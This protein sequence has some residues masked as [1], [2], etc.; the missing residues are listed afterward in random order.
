[1]KINND[2]NLGAN[3]YNLKKPED[4][5]DPGALLRADGQPLN[6]HSLS[7]DARNA[8]G[9]K[10]ATQ[11]GVLIPDFKREFDD[12]AMSKFSAHGFNDGQRK[13]ALESLSAMVK[14][15]QGLKNGA[16]GMAALPAA[17]FE[18]V[19][20][21]LMPYA[22]FACADGSVTK[23]QEALFALETSQST[24]MGSTLYDAKIAHLDLF[25]KELITTRSYANGP[26][27][28]QAQCDEI[29]VLHPGSNA[30][31]VHDIIYLKRLVS[32]ALQVERTGDTD[33]YVTGMES[34]WGQGAKREAFLKYLGNRFSEKQTAIDIVNKL[35]GDLL[36][37]KPVLPPENQLGDNYN[38]VRVATFADALMDIQTKCNYDGSLIRDIVNIKYPQDASQEDIEYGIAL[39]TSFEYK[40]N[41]DFIIRL[42]AIT[43]AVKD[44]YLGGDFKVVAC[45]SA[46][47]ILMNAIK[48]GINVPRDF[49]RIS[50]ILLPISTTAHQMDAVQKCDFYFK[51]E[52]L[53]EEIKGQDLSDDKK[54]EYIEQI[55]LSQGVL[56]IPAITAALEQRA[57]VTKLFEEHSPKTIARV[58]ENQLANVQQV[59]AD[60]NVDQPQQHQISSAAIRTFCSPSVIRK[61][62]EAARIMAERRGGNYSMLG[63]L[64]DKFVNMINILIRGKGVTDDKLQH[65][66]DIM[67]QASDSYKVLA[68]AGQIQQREANIEPLGFAE[69]INLARANPPQMQV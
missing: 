56:H 54:A 4:M 39:P 52:N 1:M 60:V 2:S 30:Y 58:L 23:L 40:A 43:G 31:E 51:L 9:K 38:Q 37:D 3:F 47:A 8:E 6:I 59:H 27:A 33:H 25:A 29:A 53:K 67:Q 35:T 32:S 65:N 22:N 18:K 26:F 66:I 55:T 45:P 17:E 62:E 64:L 20:I 16:H 49:V 14:L 10:L 63:D 69:R 44:G 11:I 41:A 34:Q 68:G 50:D 46:K 15:L 61:M 24:G 48:D 42:A 28:Y 12:M 57:A 5:L 7:E 36:G 21:K 19:K 13:D